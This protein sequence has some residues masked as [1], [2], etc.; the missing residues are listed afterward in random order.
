MT[1]FTRPVT[2]AAFADQSVYPEDVTARGTLI[3]STTVQQILE[4]ALRALGRHGQRKLSMTDIA[5]SAEVSRGT[6]YR[7]F[8]NKNA[9]LD[10]VTDYLRQRMETV[11]TDKAARG[12]LSGPE[13]VRVVLRALSDLMESREFRDIIRVDPGF[14]L[15]FLES[16]LGYFGSVVERALQHTFAEVAAV[17][18]GHL[19]GFQVADLL[20]RLTITMHLLPTTRGAAVPDRMAALWTALIDPADVPAVEEA[21]AVK[22]GAREQ[23]VAHAG[24][25]TDGMTETEQRILDGAMRALERRGV[26]KLSMSDIADEAAVSRGTLYRYF[27][28]KEAVLAG[29]AH[30]V[31]EGVRDTVLRAV[32]EEPRP[33]VRVRVVLEAFAEANERYPQA[34]RVIEIEPGFALES[35]TRSLPE[36][37]GNAQ[38]ALGEV[39]ERS[40]PVQRKLLTPAELVGLL[41][42][43]ATSLALMPPTPDRHPPAEVQLLWDSMHCGTGAVRAAAAVSV[44]SAG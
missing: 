43:I 36:R 33:E 10:G 18:A 31:R 21:G 26:R 41:V 12:D 39:V 42:R 11:V 44:D 34:G 5:E 1:R 7:H 2:I 35:L 14:A 19:T 28:D 29:V 20:V 24:A 37:V 40:T 27:Y 32:A 15:A 38:L 3:S 30:R 25:V 9:V 16:Q 22:S 6:L 4:G 23:G 17:R 8:E 13:K